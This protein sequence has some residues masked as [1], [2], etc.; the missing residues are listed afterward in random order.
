LTQFQDNF[1]AA[2]MTESRF[3]IAIILSAL[4]FLVVFIAHTL[5]AVLANSDIIYA[6]TAGFVNPFAAGYA[7][8]AIMCWF[9]LMFWVLYERHSFHIKHGWICILLG[10]IPGVAVGFALYLIVRQTQLRISPVN[11]AK[12]SM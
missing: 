3:K 9:I 4:F 2:N 1:E 5:P 6:F 11:D 7:T 12:Q 8:D 10:V